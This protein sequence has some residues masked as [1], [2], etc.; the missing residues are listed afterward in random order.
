MEAV[1]PAGEKISPL[2]SVIV[3]VYNAESY[4]E[5][6]LNSLAKQTYIRFE[7]LLIDDGSTDASAALCQRYVDMDC[8]FILFSQENKGVSAARNTGLSHA[9]GEYCTFVDSD[10]FVSTDFLEKAVELSEQT[11]ADMTVFSEFCPDDPFWHGE[12]ILTDGIYHFTQ[13]KERN[14]FLLRHFL[15]CELGFPLHGKL[16]QMNLLRRNHLKFADGI[17]FAE[18]MLFQMEW[19]MYSDC[20][21]VSSQPI[22][23][24]INRKNSLSDFARTKTALPEYERLLGKMRRPSEYWEQQ[25][26]V[27]YMVTMNN[28]FEIHP[29]R[30]MVQDVRKLEN[31]PLWHEMVNRGVHC[32][33]LFLHGLGSPKGVKLYLKMCMY[34]A[35]TKVCPAPYYYL[36]R[37]VAWIARIR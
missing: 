12:H 22:Y 33:H 36:G 18:D 7:A 23:T 27:I 30:Q 29:A 5:K 32:F 16:F 4:V 28:Q 15:K 19:L 21:A 9:K 6:C 20:V 31:S 11:G 3:P 1:L 34:G 14:R 35:C 37:L 10:D 24:Y 8:R 26:P 13:D 25:F 2:I 17:Q